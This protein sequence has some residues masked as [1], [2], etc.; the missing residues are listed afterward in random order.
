MKESPSLLNSGADTSV[1]IAISGHR[2]MAMFKRY[3]RID[4]GDGRDVMR[5][6]EIY[7]SEDKKKEE[8]DKVCCN[9]TAAGENGALGFA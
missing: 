6:L 9:I 7:L 1:I 8:T 3:N 4:L 5:K 2:T